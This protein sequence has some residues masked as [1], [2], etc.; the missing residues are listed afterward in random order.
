MMNIY[1]LLE[2]EFL[3]L[4]LVCIPWFQNVYFNICYLSVG[5]G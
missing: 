1:K 5:K 3:N 4:S 2:G